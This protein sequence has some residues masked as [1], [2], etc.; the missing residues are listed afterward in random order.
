MQPDYEKLLA[1]VHDGV[2]FTDTDRRITY[3][4]A[5]AE[6]I[7]GYGADEVVGRR[8]RDNI[9]IH[10]DENG[11]TLCH[12]RC[13]I[14]DSI[15]YRA[16]RE[17][18][19]FLHH[20]EGY[21][22]PVHVQTAPLQDTDGRIIGGVEFFKD[23]SSE[24]SMQLRIQELEQVAL[25]DALTNLPNR[26]HIEPELASRFNEMERMGLQFGF[27]LMDIDHFKRFNDTYG[28]QV[29]DAALKVVAKTLKSSMRSFDLVGRWGG[30]EFVCILRNVDLRLL[31]KISNRLR[32]LIGSCRIHHGAHSL[33]VTVS[34]GATL[35]VQDDDAV[36]LV[37]RADLLMYQSKANGR[38]RVTV[39]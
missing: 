8:C 6:R 35:A 10:V 11:H 17:A 29:G 18:K 14:V 16:N 23:I 38:N 36:S 28:H 15:Q 3:W 1:S 20:K 4:N 30:E 31:T 13:P 34:V 37:K 5:S 25:L 39:G 22:V 27:L 9:L 19:V 24:A 32:L 2:Y 21:R 33:E 7:T 26:R 12:G